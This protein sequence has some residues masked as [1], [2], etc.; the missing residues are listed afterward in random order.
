M[1][2]GDF[3]KGKKAERRSRFLKRKTKIINS[4]LTTFYLKCLSFIQIKMS[5]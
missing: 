4:G 1:T 3:E 2:G 5:S